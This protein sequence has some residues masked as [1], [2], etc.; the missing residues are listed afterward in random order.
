MQW[1]KWFPFLRWQCP[2]ALLLRNETIAAFTVTIILIP[3]AV[4]YAALAGMPLATGLYASLL[5]ALVSTLWG[6]TSR[7][8][9]GPTA[10]S[11]LLIAASLQG[12]AQPF[13]AE[14]VNLA[15]WLALLAGA[16]QM[17]LGGLRAGWLVNMISAPVLTG[18]TQAAGVLII[19]SQLPALLGLKGSLSQI[20]NAPQFQGQEMAFGVG[21]FAVLWLA[22]RYAPRLPMV[23]VV[24][25]SSGLLSYLVGFE[26]AEGAVIGHLPAGLPALV[27]PPALPW[28][29]VS[30]L[31]VP[32]MVI[33]LVSFLEVASS[34]KVQS[35]QDGSLWNDNQDLI[36]QGLAK[37]ASALSGSFPTSTSFSRSAI[38]IY[39]GATTG[40][41]A[42]ISTGMV[43]LALL[44]LMPAL[45]YVP[46][47]VLSAVVIVAVIGLIQPSQ[48]VR[49]WKISRAE[50]LTS[51]ATFSLTLLT[52]PRIYW[53]VLAGVMLGL[54]HFLYQRL[55][56]RIIEV[57]LHPDGSLRDRHLWK[58]P[59]LAPH[60]YALR[61]DAELDFAAAS[62]FERNIT[63][64]VA[65]H[66]NTTDV[67]LFAQ[68]INR[69]DAS[70]VE[71]FATLIA[72]LRQRGITLHISGIKLPVENVLRRTG[73]LAEHPLLRIYRTDAEI[74]ANGVAPA[75]MD[76]ALGGY[77]PSLKRV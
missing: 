22:K 38:N 68:P 2:N 63:E 54:I 10:L 74:L 9:V 7:L 50:T 66:P 8:S 33:A 24:V 14:W 59:P 71:V 75:F 47:A 23:L 52:A 28:S 12:M 77:D 60:M 64:Y 1:A 20:L 26:A 62:S 5:P 67:C 55:H 25:C 43:L 21:S 40:W 19:A 76:T 49:L 48:F 39:A 57:G 16:M 45:H 72:S 6:G 27:W 3:Q 73:L 65:Q 18:F 30:G 15:I 61:M 58:L 44:F 70:G 32:A 36:G 37:M 4:A 11:C 69:I 29:T 53:G 46:S 13:S 35:Q 41:S 34:A 17:V 42:L 56:P 51:L 31:L